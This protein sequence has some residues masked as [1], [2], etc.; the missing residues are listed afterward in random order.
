MKK[1][2]TIIF[3]LDGTLL[4]TLEDLK[5]AVNYALAEC[6]Y[7][8]RTLEEVRKFVGNGVRKLIERAVPSGVSIENIDKVFDIF[9]Q[10]YD[11]HATDNTRLYD[12][13]D[14][15]LNTLKQKG[16]KLAIVSNKIQSAVDILHERFFK[17]TIKISIGDRQ[18]Q[19]RK[20]APDSVLSVI[21]Y[22]NSTKAETLY[23]G[24]SEVDV[25][26]AR[27]AEVDCICVSWGFRDSKDLIAAG[28]TDIVETT[29]Q[30]IYK[31]TQKAKEL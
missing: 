14:E 12:G 5:N 19:R 4:Y 13:I 27:N 25:L 10:Y 9:K 21:E 22:L 30:L 11:I 1:Y 18:G 20:P 23:V 31:I 3:D 15:M 17:D 28:A 2:T 8:E 29:Q 16:Y 24:D 6:D 7:P 26:T